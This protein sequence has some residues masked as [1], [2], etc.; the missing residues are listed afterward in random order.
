MTIKKGTIHPT[1][2][3]RGRFVFQRDQRTTPAALAI[4][5]VV[6]VLLCCG[7]ASAAGED[8]MLVLKDGRGLTGKFAEVGGVAESV[9][10]PKKSPG[11]VDNIT[12]IIVVDDGLRRTFVYNTQVQQLVPGEANRDVRTGRRRGQGRRRDPRVAVR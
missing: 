8:A 7:G 6:A 11:G 10:S 2:S 1:P 4:S 9:L 5:A 3:R 12:P